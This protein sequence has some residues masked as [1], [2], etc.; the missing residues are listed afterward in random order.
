LVYGLKA[1]TLPLTVS[2]AS[3]GVGGHFLNTKKSR[4]KPGIKVIDVSPERSAIKDAVQ[5][6]G[7]LNHVFALNLGMGYEDLLFHKKPPD[8]LSIAST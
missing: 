4:A 7:E 6:L 2:R 1:D 3:A 8:F 5:V